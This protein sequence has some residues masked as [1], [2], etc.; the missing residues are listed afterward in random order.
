MYRQ[1][2]IKQVYTLYKVAMTIFFKLMWRRV[3]ANFVEN[4]LNNLNSSPEQNYLNFTP[5]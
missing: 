4:G 3:S 2:H 5:C 1:K